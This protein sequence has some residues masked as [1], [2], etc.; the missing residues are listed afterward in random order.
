VPKKLE[1]IV[2]V[3]YKDASQVGILTIDPE[4]NVEHVVDIS[5]DYASS[6]IDSKYR[7][8]YIAGV[9]LVDMTA[10]NFDT[11]EIEWQRAA[12]PPLPVHSADC[13]YIDDYLYAS[14]SSYYIY[15]FRYNGS[16]VFNTTIEMDKQPSGIMKFQDYIIADLQSKTGGYNY[17]ATYY[18]ASGVEKQ[19]M[20]STYQVVDFY[21]AGNNE[22]L[23]IANENDEG[24]L[25]LFNP[26]DN[27]ETVLAEIPHKI[28]C[29]AQFTESEFILG[30]PG[31]NYLF[32][33]DQLG[34]TEILPGTQ[35]FTFRFDP[36]GQQIYAS[37]LNQVFVITYPELEI[38][39]A[40][41]ISDGIL[42]LHLF[43]NR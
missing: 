38:Q 33:S 8:L 26:E 20:P 25:R 31:T 35:V 21:D 11:G 12:S 36:I 27:M 19:R 39:N 30:S 24:T 32:S 40:I 17:I 29:S 34:L 4:S 16:M 18:L 23:I 5:T 43:Y 7:Q 22:V 14:Y 15:G 3:T 28:I 2:V 42:N 1:K 41:T 6:E 37:G 10:Y 13:F 9:N